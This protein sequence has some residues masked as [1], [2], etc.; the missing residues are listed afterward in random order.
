MTPNTSEQREH[1]PHEVRAAGS[2]NW[3]MPVTMNICHG[4]GWQQGAQ[5]GCKTPEVVGI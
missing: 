3:A 2:T 1:Q 4:F 5:S